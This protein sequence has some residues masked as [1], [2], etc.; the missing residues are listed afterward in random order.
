MMVTFNHTKPKP[1]GSNVFP[2]I[3]KF[4][5]IQIC[6]EDDDNSDE[7]IDCNTLRMQSGGSPSP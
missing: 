1:N 2:L 3:Q 5:R 7:V 4:G 6:M